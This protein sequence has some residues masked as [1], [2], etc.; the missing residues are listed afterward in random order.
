[1]KITI[2]G[3]N[4]APE[5]TGIGPYNTDLANFLLER[6]HE[7]R[8]VTSFPYYPAWKKTASDKGRLYR[9]DIIDGIEVLRCWHYVPALPNTWK[10]ILH[11]ASFICSSLGRFLFAPR[12]N[13]LL[14]V[15]PP[16]LLGIAA[17][18]GSRIKRCPF[19]FHVQDMQPDAAIQLGLLKPGILTSLL[20]SLER[21]ACRKAAFVSGITQG[22]LR[23]FTG[24]GVPA[25]R[26][27]FLPNWIL[28]R[29]RQTST[30][31][32]PENAF[33][34]KHGLSPD[35]FIVAYSGNLGK[36]QGLDILL[37]AAEELSA[38]SSPTNIVLLIAGEG[39]AKE[40]LRRRTEAERL[41]VRLLPLQSEE[42]F[43]AMLREVDLFV[44]TQQKGAGA[45]FFPSKLITLLSAARPII[46]VADPDSDL[47]LAL[48]EGGFGEN[49]LPGDPKGFARTI[50]QFTSDRS[51]LSRMGMAGRTWVERF[52]R[53]TVLEDFAHHLEINFGDARDP[54]KILVHSEPE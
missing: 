3:I 27:Y 49:V 2:W 7:V 30:R 18:F 43:Q 40:E 20:F 41:P 33:R 23:M 15:S 36:K 11:E 14:V 32:M 35:D 28:K 10:R 16:L 24:K 22:M 46:T 6:G 4:Y 53:Q 39:A 52:S 17:W 45:L 1:M 5:T 31:E 26:Q 44:V 13:L 19:Q 50:V 48:Q 21:F 51:R 38:K 25:A 8:V 47:A 34:E 9:R 42:M 29:N 37:D 12:P 54:I